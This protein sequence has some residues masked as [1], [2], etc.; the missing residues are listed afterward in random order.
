MVKL[1]RSTNLYRGSGLGVKY[2]VLLVAAMVTLIFWA[3]HRT[4]SGN[5]STLILI[6]AIAFAVGGFGWAI[7]DIVKAF[8]KPHKDE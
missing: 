3:F 7:F 2:Y 1:K 8:K 6:A 5:S 4:Y